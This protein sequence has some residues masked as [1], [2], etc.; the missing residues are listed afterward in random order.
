M[1]APGKVLAAALPLEGAAGAT[2]RYNRTALAALRQE[3]VF[4]R[5]AVA[6]GDCVPICL[7]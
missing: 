6:Q 2:N 5:N 4:R 7:R 1:F 3:Q